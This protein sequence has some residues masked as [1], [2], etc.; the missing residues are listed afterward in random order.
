M[1]DFPRRYGSNFL[2][3]D[4][5]QDLTAGRLAGEADRLLGGAGFDHRVV[6]VDPAAYFETLRPGFVELGWSTS[7]YVLMVLRH[8]PPTPPAL[9]QAREVT[10]SDIVALLEQHVRAH[11]DRGES[12]V[13]T[14]ADYPAKLERQAGARLFMAEADGRPGASC[15]LYLDGAEAQV[16]SV[17][18][19]EEF[20]GRNL[21]TAVVLA[22]IA[23]A[24]L[25]GAEWIHLY[26][27]ADDWPAA[28]YRRLGFEDAGSFGEFSLYPEG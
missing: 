24:R 23:A 22:A 8:E 19:L 14:L 16:E 12:T 1:M 5:E 20:R 4:G 27:E 28:W 11:P 6:V 2:W 26:A 10:H 7:R 13:R 9:P 18:T 15:E 3:V 25:A 17:Q 21:G